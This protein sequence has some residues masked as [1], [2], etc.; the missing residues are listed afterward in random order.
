[1]NTTMLVPLMLFG[2]VPFTIFLFFRLEPHRAVLFS[3]I[4]GWLFLPTTGYDLQGLPAYSKSMAIALGLVLGG[5][6]SGQRRVAS[7]K[8]TIY[9]LPMILWCLCPIPSS[10]TNQLG[11]YDGLSGVLN[12][13]IVWG[14]PYFAG[15]IYFNNMDTL[16]DLCLGI[17]IGGLLYVPLCLYE[18]RMS[19]QLNNIFYGFFQHEWVQ[20]KRYGGWRP[21]VFMQHGLMVSLW[22]AISSTAAFWLGRIGVVKHIKGISITVLSIALIITTIL[23]K[24]ANGWAMLVLGCGGYLAFLHFKSGKPFQIFLLLVPLY[25]FL[26]ISG[27]V[28]GAQVLSLVDP[29]FDLDR[30]S[31]LGIRLVQEDLFVD[32]TMEHPLFGWGRM[33]RGWPRIEWS[34]SK[35]VKMIDALWLIVFN[36]NGFVGIL[37]W[38]SMMLIGPWMVLHAFRKQQFDTAFSHSGPI[39][40]SLISIM[41]MID[42]L[43]NGMINPVYMIAS[44][45]LLGSYLNQGLFHETRRI[46]PTNRVP[47][48]KEKCISGDISGFGRHNR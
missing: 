23:C 43:A 34:G 29:V 2:W 7:F 11:L 8:W 9:D 36:L 33:G 27:G 20:H 39:L 22:M 6:L 46:K 42:S 35:A 45:G 32:K 24:S 47:K 41:F 37:S 21:I 10:L 31:S 18:I 14:V 44:G 26:R 25:I 30:T 12:H 1:M 40:L 19:P 13:I 15:R 5:R 28:S 16:K 38:I 3:V 48:N 17:V 4:G